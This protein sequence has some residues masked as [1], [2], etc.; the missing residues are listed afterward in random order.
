MAFDTV[1][2][3]Y[4]IVS[5]NLFEIVGFSDSELVGLVVRSFLENGPTG[6]IGWSQLR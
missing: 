3:P 1:R 2:L 4:R 5:V 6:R